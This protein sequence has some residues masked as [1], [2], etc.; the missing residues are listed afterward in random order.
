MPTHVDWGTSDHTLLIWRAVGELTL[1]D[2]LSASKRI[3][4]LVKTT[5]HPVTVMIDLRKCQHTSHNFIPTMREQIANMQG[6]NGEIVVLSKTQFWQSIYQI[7]AQSSIGV[8]LPRV[9]FHITQD[10]SSD[11]R[12]ALS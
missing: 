5:S 10:D 4:A 11:F 12:A 2:Y 7:A 9:R 6:F 3:G 8:K 1:E